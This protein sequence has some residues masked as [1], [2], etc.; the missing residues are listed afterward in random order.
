MHKNPGPNNNILLLQIIVL[1]QK[2]N[3]GRAQGQGQISHLYRLPRNN[4]NK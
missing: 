3:W 2:K 1:N 4:K